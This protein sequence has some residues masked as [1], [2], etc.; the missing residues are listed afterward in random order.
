MPTPPDPTDCQEVV[1]ASLG[2]TK[3]DLPALRGCLDAQ[4]VCDA[5]ALRTNIEGS[6]SLTR[7]KGS[8]PRRVPLPMTVQQAMALAV[9]TGVDVV[10]TVEIDGEIMDHVCKVTQHCSVVPPL[11]RVSPSV[12]VR[13]G[14]D[15]TQRACVRTDTSFPPHFDVPLVTACSPASTK[16]VHSPIA[17]A[18]L[19]VVA[20][21]P[22]LRM[23]PTYRGADFYVVEASDGGWLMEAGHE[24]EDGP[25]G[26]KHVQQGDVQVVK[27]EA[28]I[29][30]WALANEILAGDLE[31]AQRELASLREREPDRKAAA[32]WLASSMAAEEVK[33]AAMVDAGGEPLEVIGKWAG[34]FAIAGHMA[35]QALVSKPV[36]A[37]FAVVAREPHP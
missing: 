25:F 34:G 6:A 35:G 4:I 23:P 10:L 22:E 15:E 28:I 31:A 37:P 14:L 29:D 16:H 20:D 18:G 27:A 5:E 8:F 1:L 11:F 19:A 12:P 32:L 17:P 3:R 9:D 21:E 36:P 26:K 2:M 13:R 7:A 33:I 24:N 30:A